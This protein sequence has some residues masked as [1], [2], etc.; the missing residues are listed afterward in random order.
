M[1]GDGGVRRDAGPPGTGQ[2]ESLSH[3]GL[4]HPGAHVEAGVGARGVKVRELGVADRLLPD[5]SPGRIVDVRPLDRCTRG[6]L[7]ELPRANKALALRPR[8]SGSH[9]KR[10]SETLGRLS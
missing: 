4:G 5:G 10:V 6:I 7:K 1:R 2:E 3:G 8:T 9:F